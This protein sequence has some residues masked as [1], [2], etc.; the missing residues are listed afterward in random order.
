MGG[1]VYLTGAGA[2]AAELITARA[3]EVIASADVVIYDHLAN[4]SL[5]NSVPDECE[6]VYAGKC[7]GNH[8]LVQEETNRL[9]VEYAIKGK[10][11]VRLKGGDPFVFGRGGEEAEYLREKGIAFELVPGVSSCYSAAEYSGIPVTHRDCSP[12]FHV[13]TGHNKKGNSGEDYEALAKMK[14]TLV[15]LMGMK[16][17]GQIADRLIANGK[18]PETPAAVISRGTTELQ[19]NVTAP[20]SEIAEAA[21]EMPMPGIILVGDAVGK[22]VDWI[23]R[24]G[25]YG[26]KILAI[27]TKQSTERLRGEIHKRNGTLTEISLIRTVD[28][29]K[30]KFDSLELENYSHI[31]FFSNTGVNA[32]FE[33]IGRRRLD[34]RRLYGIRFAVTGKSCADALAEH[35]IY[36]DIMPDIF[37]SKE[38]AKMLAAELTEN[39]NVLI[40]RAQN[41]SNAVSE[42]LSDK[43]IRF[44]DMPV[45]RTEI[46]FRKKEL[47]NLCGDFDYITVM[48]G[49]AA[50]ALKKMYSGNGK[51]IS[52]GN[53]TTRAAEAEGLRVY[54]TAARADAEGIAEAIMEDII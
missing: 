39:D 28:I 37:N 9:M 40:L 17:I 46:D 45:Y 23:D 31:V 30:E 10:R 4:A 8:H 6:L 41:S 26:K 34:V 24:S 36:A 11:V 22:R 49:S 27:G 29:N 44:T 33:S 38:L 35:G 7:A 2:G 18:S 51:L 3:A 1:K 47:L 48:S 19:K 12:A 15:F 52:I 13:I 20:L 14:G 16:N 21:K 53:S 54:K 5:L 43:G 42:M 32:F 50:R 25:L